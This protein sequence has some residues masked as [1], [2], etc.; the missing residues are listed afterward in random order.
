MSF[1]LDALRKSE[2]E[3]DRHLLPGVVQA[4]RSGRSSRSLRWILVICICAFVLNLAALSYLFLREPRG[5]G[6]TGVAITDAGTVPSAGASLATPT[7]PVAPAVGA[8]RSLAEEAM[9]S[10]RSTPYT[11]DRKSTRLNSSH[12]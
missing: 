1:I 5:A 4:P 8:V 11:E 9:A 7:A 2:H 10:G 6:P 12:T 3:R